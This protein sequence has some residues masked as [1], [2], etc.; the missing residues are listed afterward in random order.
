MS[1]RRSA[2][3]RICLRARHGR[4]RPPGWSGNLVQL[5]D[6]DGAL[7]F[8]GFDHMTIVDDLVAHIDRRAV[9]LE[10]PLDDLDGAVDTGAKTA[11]RGQIDGQLALAHRMLIGA[12]MAVFGQTRWSGI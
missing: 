3:G 11:R 10:R 5:L 6:E 8:Q 1:S 12:G 4:K 9:A 7:L 2:S